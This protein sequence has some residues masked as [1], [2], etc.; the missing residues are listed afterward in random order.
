MLTLEQRQE[1]D[2]VDWAKYRG[3][4]IGE[5]TIIDEVTADDIGMKATHS[6]WFFGKFGFFKVDLEGINERK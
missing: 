3:H 4:I 6:P 1:F 5:I 2:A